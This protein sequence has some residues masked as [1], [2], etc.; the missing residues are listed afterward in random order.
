ML[1]DANDLHTASLGP[2][3]DCT[4]VHLNLIFLAQYVR[5]GDA[6]APRNPS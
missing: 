6:P 5:Y 4:S 2:Q 3:D 1:P